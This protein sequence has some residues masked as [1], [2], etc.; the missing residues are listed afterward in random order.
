MASPCSVNRSLPERL[1]RYSRVSKPS[2]LTSLQK[3][4]QLD[5]FQLHPSFFAF[6][7]F[8]HFI[9]LPYIRHREVGVIGEREAERLPVYVPDSRYQYQV[10]IQC[11]RDSKT[12]LIT[13]KEK[14]KEKGKQSASKIFQ[15]K[16]SNKDSLRVSCY[17]LGQHL[18]SSSTGLSSKSTKDFPRESFGGNGGGFSSIFQCLFLANP[19]CSSWPDLPTLS[20]QQTIHE[21]DS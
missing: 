2:T 21:Q 1:S 19:C 7:K 3:S 4:Q 8:L 20:L 14:S 17:Q 10:P 5:H 15:W 16:C 9:F 12:K 11:Q 13:V 18:I 6:I